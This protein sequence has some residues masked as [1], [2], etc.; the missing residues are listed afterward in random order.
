MN[1]KAKN[2]AISLMLSGGLSMTAGVVSLAQAEF[3]SE[4]L[5][6]VCAAELGGK[7]QMQ[8]IMS[9]EDLA[10]RPIPEL[11]IVTYKADGTPATTFNNYFGKGASDLWKQ[12]SGTITIGH[13]KNRCFK[14]SMQTR[15]LGTQAWQS[16]QAEAVT[17]QSGGKRIN[18]VSMPVGNIVVFLTAIKSNGGTELPS[19]TG[20][21]QQ[22]YDINLPPEK[23]KEKKKGGSNADDLMEVEPDLAYRGVSL[24]RDDDFSDCYTNFTGPGDLEYVGDENNDDTESLTV[25][26]GFSATLWE[27]RDFTGRSITLLCGHYILEGELQGVSSVQVRASKELDCDYVSSDAADA[28][29]NA[30]TYGA[31]P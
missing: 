4:F 21:F 28:L 16:L 1:G 25:G 7:T 9:Q 29:R 17:E 27:H 22:N 2:L 31:W 26:K 12:G 23:K 3:K 14:F 5:Y 20:N 30:E 10:G 11:A 24:C 6:E 8:V 13:K 15:A 18:S 19:V